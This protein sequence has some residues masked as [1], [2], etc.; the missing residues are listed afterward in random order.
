MYTP[1]IANWSIVSLDWSAWKW[2]PDGWASRKPMDCE[3]VLFSEAQSA[4][5]G[6]SRARAKAWVYRN[7]CKALPWFSSVRKVL[8]DPAYA[9]WFL[10]YAAT[11]PIN[12]SA[13]YSPRCDPNSG[14]C[15]GYYHDSTQSPDYARMPACPITGDCSIQVPGFPQGDGNC[16]APACDVGGVVPVG[17]YVFDPRA[18]NVSV[19][20]QTLGQ[21]WIS[22]YL[23]S[24]TGAG[25]S[26]ITG[27]YF[28]DAVNAQGLCSELDSHQ[29]ADLGLGPAEGAAVAAAYRSNFEFINAEL[30]RR[31]A[32]TEQLLQKVRAPGR[33]GDCAALFR[34]GLCKAN[35]PAMLL[36]LGD[37]DAVELG[38]A[39]FLLGRG[40]YAW[41][42]H[43]WQGCGSPD[44]NQKTRWPAWH[45]GLFDAD[46]GVPVDALCEEREPGVFSRRWSRAVVSVN[47]SSL[48]A[49]ITML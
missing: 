33:P 40:P 49:N 23:F 6:S 17:E 44:V 36:D 13:Y 47:C 30:V 5:A 32:F 1:A 31:G 20:G 43:T 41:Y 8:E 24:G 16:T 2:G 45:A 42:G 34:G 18:F 15:S 48:S 39:T 22:D 3:E 10:K 14:L 19:K 25:N 7:T 4:V 12:G 38:F 9:P 28:D 29:A 21:W 26:N 27:F 37:D 35:P 11:P 46:Y